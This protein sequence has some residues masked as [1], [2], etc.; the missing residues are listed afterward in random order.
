MITLNDI[1]L[2][3][4]TREICARIERDISLERLSLFF[5]RAWPGFGTVGLALPTMYRAWPPHPPRI[6]HLLWPNGASRW[7]YFL[8]LAHVDQVNAI[9]DSLFGANSSITTPGTL[10]ISS[11]DQD[12]EDVETLTIKGM[13]C[14]SP[15]PLYRVLNDDGSSDNGMYLLPLVDQRYFWWQYPTPDFAISESAGKTWANL[16]TA[17]NT[18]LGITITT[19]TIATAYLQ[20]SKALGLQY[21]ALP[22]II[23]S[24]C[25]NI[26]HKLIANWDGSVKTQAFGTALKALQDDAKNAA[27]FRGVRA[28]GGKYL[29]QY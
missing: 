25:A 4:P 12:D 14:F 21:E 28:G 2:A 18:A 8:G 22:P 3:V 1:G 10:V 26:G 29:A 13:T 24:I 23:D 19:D 6:N 16:F 11:Q 5:S 17:I 20:P 9:H 15:V 27:D 7:G